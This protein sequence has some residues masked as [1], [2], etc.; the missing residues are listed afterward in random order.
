VEINALET[1]NSR[2]P[3]LFLNFFPPD[4]KNYHI[5][6]IRTGDLETI[7]VLR[8]GE[9]PPEFQDCKEREDTG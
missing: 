9:G 1:L 5:I 4:L 7:R 6:R 3:E 8:P 2:I